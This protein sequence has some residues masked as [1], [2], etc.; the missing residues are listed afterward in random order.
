M[1]NIIGGGK[2]VLIIT[3]YTDIARDYND[4]SHEELFELTLPSK[5]KY[6]K[7]QGYDLLT[8]RSFGDGSPYGLTKN[9]SPTIS[10]LYREHIGFLRAII[11]FEMLFI[12]ETVF[13][14]DADSIITNHDYDLNSFGVNAKKT[15]YASYDWEWKNSFSAGNF[16]LH[17]TPVWREFFGLFLNLA[18][19]QFKDHPAQEQATLNFIHKNTNMS[20]TIQ[21]LDHKYLGAV[22]KELENTNTWISSKRPKINWPWDKT[23]FLSHVA[24][25]PNNE[26][27]KVIKNNFSEYI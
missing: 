1:T 12:Y 7:K 3:G 14:I 2:K 5:Q 23:C 6:A 9:Y 4:A 26:R 21:V 25:L 16:I 24:G 22:P 20:E 15:L 11:A 17:R 27:I 18:I 13:W 8:M 19:H 10:N